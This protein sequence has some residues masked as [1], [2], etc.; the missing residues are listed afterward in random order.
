VQ[1]VSGRRPRADRDAVP[2]IRGERGSFAR[3]VL[4][5]RHP[6]IIEQVRTSHPYGPRQQRRLDALLR[7]A[8]HGTVELPQAAED[9]GRWPDRGAWAA[10]LE[11][12]R[13][14][15]FVEVP[16]LVAEAWFYR[17]LLD[18]VE[19]VEP[20]PWHG[21]DPFAPMKLAELRE[22]PALPAPPDRLDR[23]ALLQ[24]SVWGNQA[25]LGFQLV[26]GASARRRADGALVVDDTSRFWAVLDRGGLDVAWICDNAGRELVADLL[27]VERLLADG[28]ASSVTLHVKPMPH[29][30][31]DATARDLADCI[32]ALAGV[33][34]PD[35]GARLRAAAAAGRL[36]VGASPFWCAP[37]EL[38]DRPPALADELDA[39]DLVVVKGDLNYRRLVGDA[40]W[41]PSTAF[42]DTVQLTRPVA[43]LRTLKSDVVVGVDDATVAAL[44]ESSPGWR[45]DGSYA[46][47]QV[48]D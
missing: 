45:T 23:D 42:A 30:V 4:E 17:L 26:A 31:S 47:V 22:L 44:D 9:E 19:F 3:S 40:A 39:A 21:V 48:R 27:L 16:F 34:A 20:A 24:A 33:G 13:G 32:G 41:P 43:A 18:A 15:L 14:R 7:D 1:E 12:H 5:R 46:L 6:A 37:L 35:A 8:L 2:T 25:D 38:R 11:P 28:L 36:R 29:F 10:W